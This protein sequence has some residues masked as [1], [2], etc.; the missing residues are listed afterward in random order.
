MKAGTAHQVED[1]VEIE[2]RLVH[3]QVSVHNQRVAGFLVVELQVPA[4][5]ERIEAELFNEANAL[6]QI[7][8]VAVLQE[9]DDA[10]SSHALAPTVLSV[11]VEK[12]NAIAGE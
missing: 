9:R 11:D 1:A 2:Q 3:I 8:P 5:F 12:K 10:F 7:L 6:L 4:V